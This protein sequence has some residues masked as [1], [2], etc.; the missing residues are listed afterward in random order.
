MC[1]QFPL[2]K[3]EGIFAGDNKSMG[4]EMTKFS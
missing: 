1:P 3:F 2:L 4:H